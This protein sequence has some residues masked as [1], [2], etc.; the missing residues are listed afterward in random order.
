MRNCVEEGCG[1]YGEEAEEGCR[2]YGE[3]QRG[4]KRG[5]SR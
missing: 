4:L 3:V 1:E 2:F 5:K